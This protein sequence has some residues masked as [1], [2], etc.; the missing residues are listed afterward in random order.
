MANGTPASGTI[1]ALANAVLNFAQDWRRALILV[2]LGLTALLGTM[3]YQARERVV[4]ALEELVRQPPPARLDQ[5]AAPTVAAELL[6]ELP[7]KPRLVL[8]LG[9]DVLANVAWLIAGAAVPEAAPVLADYRRALEAGV[10]YLSAARASNALVIGV[11]NGAIM[12]G[13]MPVGRGENGVLVTAG[14]HSVCVAGIPPPMGELVGAILVGYAG[15]VLSDVDQEAAR[16]LLVQASE[17][18]VGWATSH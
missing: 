13:P 1:A 17:T 14:I 8:V 16:P 15:D 9:V 12:C 6:A 7:R 4:S 2:V 5:A 18:L 11:L 3:V 10:P